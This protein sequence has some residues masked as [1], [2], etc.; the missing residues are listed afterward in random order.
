[1][2][3]RL[4]CATPP[5]DARTHAVGAKQSAMFPAGI[6]ITKGAQGAYED[7]AQLWWVS[8]SVTGVINE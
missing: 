4:S 5:N 8:N 1:M 2:A 7:V 3:A 6:G